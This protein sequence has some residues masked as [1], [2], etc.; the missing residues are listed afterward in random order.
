VVN[1]IQDVRGGLR[2]LGTRPGFAFTAVAMLA[3]GTGINGAVFT[4][5]D[6][7]LF[8]GFRHVQRNDQIVRVGTTRDFIYYPD[9]VEWRE[10][11][12]S[13]ND[14]ALVR[15]YFHT[16]D[17][18]RDSPETLFTTEVTTNTFTLLGVRP[19]L[20][21]DFLPADAEPG[22]EPVIILRHDLWRRRFGAD[23]N[24]IGRPV[25]VGGVAMTVVGVMP[26]GFSFPAE[27]EL[28]TPLVPTAAALRRETGYARHAYGRL[29][30]GSRLDTARAELETVGRRLEQAFPGTNHNVVPV[31]SGFDEWFVGPAARTL[32]KGL[33]GAVGCILLI[34]CVNVANLF[35]LQAIGR[36]QEMA[37]RLALGAGIWRVVRQFV[38]EGLL[39][40]ALGGVIGYWLALVGVHLFTLADP[41]SA[42]LALEIDR[43]VVVYLSAIAATTGLAGGLATATYLAKLSAAGVSTAANRTVAGGRGATRLSY[44]FVG[45]EMALAVTLLAGAGVTVRSLVRVSTADVGVDAA[46]VLTASLYLPPER[47]TSTEA[48]RAFYRDLGERLAALPGMEAVAFGAV[49]P[50]ERTARVAFELA[51]APALD[52]R[53]RPTAAVN[54]ISPDY[55]RVL[56]ASIVAGRDL[57][58]SDDAPDSAVVLVNRRFAD[59]Q[60]PRQSPLGKR[61]RLFPAS[62]ATPP[63]A[64]LTVVG[65]ASNIVQNDRTRQTFEPMVYVSYAQQPQPNMFAFGRSRLPPGSLAAALRRE[66]YAMDP[67]LPVPAL[68]P[69]DT[70]LDRSYAIERNT[71]VLF[72]GFAM[73]A[74]LLATVGLSGVVAHAVSRRTRE[75]GIRV[76]VGATQRD[77]L[78][79]FLKSGLSAAGGGLV[80]GLA[81]SVAVNQLLKSQLVGVSPAD[82]VALTA[83]SGV[84]LLA[85]GV[86]GWVPARRAAR[87][88]PVVALKR[89]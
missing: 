33:W 65:V 81:M 86:G 46:K 69:L 14:L 62:P 21:R 6:A 84:L 52:E 72:G 79:H 77:I 34:V 63:T 44:A 82:P 16:F 74:L 5:V 88:D 12:A 18:G 3:V 78:A 73:I 56:G 43:T 42:V 23:T 31:V 2:S 28:W 47:Y 48:R 9:F 30:E 13:L 76:A 55:F 75:I 4:L 83:A 22:A 64:W 24:V 53:T 36:S 85:A 71:T 60:W 59:L 58:A 15:G 51:D 50:T 11:V 39:L 1:L 35:V 10:Q 7:A 38:I 40:S 57:Q 67:H 27:Q 70:R 54:V 26:E 29:A 20:G 89:D 17:T 25:R 32:Y 45:V 80:A 41:N 66:V 19:S 61:L 68:S 49:A 37:V 87:V 8:K